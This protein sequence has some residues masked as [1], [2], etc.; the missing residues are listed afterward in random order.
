L[1]AL[2]TLLGR[3]PS[4]GITTATQL[5]AMPRPVPVGLPS[6]LLERRP[7]VVAA[8]RRVAAAFN[9]IQEA[10]AARLPSI[11]LTAAI[12]SIS[13]DLFVLKERDNP[14]W[15]GSAGLFAPLFRGGELKAQQDIRTA[16]QK[17]AMAE[18][19]SVGLR[20]FNE[21]EN[22]LSMEFA[23]R[24]REVILRATVADH[25]RALELAHERFRQG[26]IDFREVSQQQLA[27]YAAN[28]AL[29]RVQSEALVQRVNLYLALGGSFEASQPAAGRGRGDAG[30]R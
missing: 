25:Q 7:D 14:V 10:K 15:S 11:S 26:A 17:Q 12:S 28:T 1:R 22:A 5:P 30:G 23:L 27:L 13:S 20:A 2:E 3:Y 16:E 9:R 29:L 21:V 4:A 6:E 18:Y 24:E 19:A 8:E